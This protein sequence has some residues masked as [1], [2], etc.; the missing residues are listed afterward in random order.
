MIWQKI[1]LSLIQQLCTAQCCLEGENIMISWSYELQLSILKVTKVQ[2]NSLLI[3]WILSKGLSI[4]PIQHGL[5][6]DV[7]TRALAI[8]ANENFKA[9]FIYKNTS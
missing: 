5:W 4:D 7:I 9:V 8:I 2:H 6:Y 1:H 3:S